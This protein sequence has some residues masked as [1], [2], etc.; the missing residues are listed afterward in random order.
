MP[1]WQA[2][3]SDLVAPL[4]AGFPFE[5]TVLTLSLSSVLRRGRISDRASVSLDG[6]IM[7]NYRDIVVDCC[8]QIVWEVTFGIL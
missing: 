7:T 8:I 3:S 4:V 5:S 1:T 2:V 6:A